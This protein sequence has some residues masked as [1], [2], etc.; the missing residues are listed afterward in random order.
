MHFG[1]LLEFPERDNSNKYVLYEEIRNETNPFLDII[2][3][4]LMILCN[5]TFI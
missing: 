2:L 1:N 4:Y 3:L 5:S